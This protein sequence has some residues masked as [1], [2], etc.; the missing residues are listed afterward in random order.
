MI[1]AATLVKKYQLEKHPEGGYYKET[2]K[3]N[4]VLPSESLPKDFGGDRVCSTA[5]YFL[6]EQGQFSAFHK[7]KSDE[8]WHFYTGKTLEIF[9]LFENGNLEI[10]KLGNNIEHGEVF[11]YVVPA[12]CWFASRPAAHS[13]FCFVGCTVAPGFDFRDFELAKKEELLMEYPQ[14][15]SILEELCIL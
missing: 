2:Y 11:Q 1:N 3:S 7:I 9:I 15:K 14:H 10:I 12:N 5:I 13:N 8:C 6:L 4:V